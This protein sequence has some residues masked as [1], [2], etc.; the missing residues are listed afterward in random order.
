[1][2]DPVK[3]NNSLSL[4]TEATDLTVGLNVEKMTTINVWIDGGCSDNGTTYAVGG[5]GIFW[6][7]DDNRNKSIPLGEMELDGSYT[8][9]RAEIYAAIL[10]L[11]QAEQLQLKKV[12]VKTDSQYVTNGM[13][14]YIHKWKI[15]GWISSSKE[16]VKNKNLWIKLDALH[17][18]NVSLG[19]Q[20]TWEYVKGHVD[21]GNIQADALASKAI[22]KAKIK[23]KETEKLVSLQESAHND[24]V[25]GEAKSKCPICRDQQNDNKAIQCNSC[26]QWVH[27]HCT[28]L[29]RY[30]LYVYQSTKRKFT[31][32]KC[33]QTPDNFLKEWVCS[34]TSRIHKSTPATDEDDVGQ[35]VI[36]VHT[37]VGT[38]TDLATKTQG[39]AEQNDTT[40]EDK[41]TQ[42]VSTMTDLA[43]RSLGLQTAS[44]RI[45]INSYNVS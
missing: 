40:Y 34:H 3:D 9:N 1:M 29:P 22:E 4:Q 20:I 33:A 31:C 16:P 38:M 18:R 13:R 28:Q 44:D 45:T 7:L 39:K 2:S 42:S 41:H 36:K 6:G 12:C 27:Y 30:Q 37:S 19:M 11:E 15:N 24:D 32:E 17:Q 5:V 8:N 26:L 43:T 14:S 25:D 21:Q 23:K 10:A 35:F